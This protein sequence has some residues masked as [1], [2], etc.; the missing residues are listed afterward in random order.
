MSYKRELPIMLVKVY[1]C[2]VPFV[3]HKYEWNVD[4]THDTFVGVLHKMISGS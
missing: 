3:S 4:T 2:L 1:A